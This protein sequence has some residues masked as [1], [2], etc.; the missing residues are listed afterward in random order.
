[1]DCEYCMYYEYDEEFE[2]FAC[3]RENALDEDDMYRII[4][5][6]AQECPFFRA[7]NEYQIVKKQI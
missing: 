2:E 1:M 7:G 6:G 5:R 4:S 3:S